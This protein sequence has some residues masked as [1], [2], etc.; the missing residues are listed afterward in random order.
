[1]T[2]EKL[3]AVAKDPKAFLLKSRMA[4][5]RIEAKRRRIET[6]R[7]LAESITVTLKPDGGASGGG[8]KEGIVATAV[9]NIVDLENEIINEIEGLVEAE[10][11][12]REVIRELVYDGRYMAVLEMRYLNGYDWEDIGARLYYSKDW[13]CRLHGAA[14]K[15]IKGRIKSLP[16][17][18]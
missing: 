17:A 12:I 15:D 11:D 5:A 14:L 3:E 2:Q 18:I 8:Y 1:M 10:R 4:E 16:S 7:E 9:A 13:V 6:W